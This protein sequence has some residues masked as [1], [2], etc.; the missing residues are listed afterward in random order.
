MK[1]LL[2]KYACM[3]TTAHSS[4]AMFQNVSPNHLAFFLKNNKQLYFQLL[5]FCVDIPRN[6]PSGWDG[7]GEQSELTL[8]GSR[9]RGRRGML[10]LVLPWFSGFS[11]SLAP[12]Y[13]G[14]K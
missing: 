8:L 14:G 2:E 12:F 1:T 13:V 4:C 9:A 10:S 6:V 7:E 11:K 3:Y 5:R